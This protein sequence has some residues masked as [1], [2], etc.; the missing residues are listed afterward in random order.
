MRFPTNDDPYS[1]KPTHHYDPS[2]TMQDPHKQFTNR[3][4]NFE[5]PTNVQDID[6]ITFPIDLS[7]LDSTLNLYSILPINQT[8]LPDVN[9]LSLAPELDLASLVL[10]IIIVNSPLKDHHDQVELKRPRIKA[11]K[12]MKV[13]TQISSAMS[14]S[15]HITRIE[16]QHRALLLVLQI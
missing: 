7:S 8:N 15:I 10:L 5:I 12:T 4:E 2:A 9:T 1:L 11:K 16:A 3:T 14:K 6:D 13:S